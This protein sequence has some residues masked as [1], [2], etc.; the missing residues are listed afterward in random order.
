MNWLKAIKQLL[1]RFWADLF[2]DGD[3]LLGV[4][5]LLFLYSK[6]TD[7]QY[8]NW[9]NGMIAANLDVEQSRLP[10]PI[11][12]EA[13]SI[14]R[15]WYSWNKL[16][17]ES[18]ASKF[19]NHRYYDDAP[20]SDYG[21]VAYSK[22]S[23]DTPDY[24]IDHMYGYK[25]ILL[26]GLDYDFADG[27][28]LFYVDPATLQLELVKVTDSKGDLHLY[29]KFFGISL[30][31]QKVCDPVT[32]FESS[33]LNPC[34][35]IAWDI[36]QNGATYY[37]TKQLLGKATGSVI[38]ESDGVIDA[39]WKEQDYFCVSVNSKP[40]MSKQP[41]ALLEAG[42]TF[43]EDA[44]GKEVSM[45]TV[46]FGSLA[47]YKGTDEVTAEQVP[48]IKVM[49]DAGQLTALN[50]NQEVYEVEGMLVLPLV[51]DG[52]TVQ[53][54]KDVCAAN[55]K[56]E[57]CPYVQVGTYNTETQAF[58]ENA[59]SFITKKLRRG[60]SVTVRLVAN[61]LDYLAAAIQCI[62]KSSCASGIINVYVAAG[63]EPPDEKDIITISA[64]APAIPED[65]NLQYYNIVDKLL[66]KVVY[67]N[68][69]YVWSKNGQPD[70]NVNYKNLA[71]DKLYRY[72]HGEMKDV[73]DAADSNEANL[74]LSV[75][76]A[77]AGMMA[78][79]VVETLTIKDE[80]AEA[81]V[82]L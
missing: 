1:G 13:D 19:I 67:K 53:A 69:T 31:T 15:E 3:F 38:C 73:T 68:D 46:L 27:R 58:E 26:R 47:V 36:H 10:Y 72:V 79:A 57:Y 30:Q 82:V 34:S 32:G 28:F 29:Y 45:G 71:D 50:K 33:W 12:I 9:R 41:L 51:G 78:V 49:T 66:Y 23:I 25:K 5:Y 52:F 4:E 63:T 42:E 80:S 55:M 65:K 21:W 39:A 17:A 59:Y 14:E 37:N 61:C 43:E 44:V 74:T 22:E 81:E 2:G 75:F 62:R 20:E 54:Y 40:Y 8:L 35:N 70:S 77:D 24:L 16:W 64:I 11:F 7:N 6:L 76:A 48:G 18:S 56:N 60:R